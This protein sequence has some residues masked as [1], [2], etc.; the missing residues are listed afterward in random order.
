M[1]RYGFL[2]GESKQESVIRQSG[3]GGEVPPLVAL[4]NSRIQQIIYKHC[5]MDFEFTID[6][7]SQK[8]VDKFIHIFLYVSIVFLVLLGFVFQNLLYTI[9]SFIG[10]IIICIAVTLPSYPQ[11]NR[12]RVEWLKVKI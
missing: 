4:K 2:A 12:S 7:E 1:T 9:G 3:G 8:F 6:F 11:Y 10:F 5:S